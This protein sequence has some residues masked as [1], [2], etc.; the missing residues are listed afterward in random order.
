M[1]GKEPKAKFYYIIFFPGGGGSSSLGKVTRKE[2]GRRFKSCPPGSQ[3]VRVTKKNGGQVVA[4]VP[5]PKI[6]GGS[7][8]RFCY[9]GA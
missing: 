3:L 9:K 8:R 2:A 4:V 6:P 5:S 7:S 1:G